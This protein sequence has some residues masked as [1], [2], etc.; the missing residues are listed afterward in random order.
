MTNLDCIIGGRYPCDYCRHLLTYT[1]DETGD[2]CAECE[3]EDEI[4]ETLEGWEPFTGDVMDYRGYRCPRFEP[5]LIR[6][7]DI[8]PETVLLGGVVLI[9]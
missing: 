7:S 1:D 4:V 5:N 9:V 6:A 8:C 2:G 3:M